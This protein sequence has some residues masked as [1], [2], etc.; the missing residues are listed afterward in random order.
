MTVADV[1]T[2]IKIKGQFKMPNIHQA[3]L[4]EAP[5][6]K[7]YHALTTEEGLSAWWTPGAKAT[8]ETS[9]IARFPFGTEYFKEMKVTELKPFT[10]VRWLC[11]SGTAEWIGT[12]LS[13]DLVSFDKRTFSDRHP[14]LSGQLQQLRHGEKGTVV[15][16]HHDNWRDETPMFAECNYTWAQ[17]LRSLKLFCETGKGRPFPDQHRVER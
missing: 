3:L 13:F 11:I 17:F 15:I 16:F 7:I 2:K 5:D 6:E 4:I 12:S 14:E 9:T 1:S 10:H 8:P